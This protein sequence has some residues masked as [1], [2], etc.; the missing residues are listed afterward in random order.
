MV[1]GRG[2]WESRGEFGELEIQHRSGHG[3][4]QGTGESAD[5][6][7]VKRGTRDLSEGNSNSLRSA[8]VC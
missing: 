3:K 4:V 6:N 2:E 5:G 1:T 8:G 7:A